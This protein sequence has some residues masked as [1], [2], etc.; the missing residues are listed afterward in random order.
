MVN[1]SRFYLSMTQTGV[2]QT[3]FLSDSVWSVA[4][5]HCSVCNW[6]SLSLPLKSPLNPHLT[7][8]PFRFGQFQ[9]DCT[10]TGTVSWKKL[11][12]DWSS[13]CTDQLQRIQCWGQ[14]GLLW[15][16]QGLTHKKAAKNEHFSQRGRVIYI[17]HAPSNP[18]ED[19][20]VSANKTVQVAT[21]FPTESTR[22][23]LK[24]RDDDQEESGW[25]RAAYCFSKQV[26]GWTGQS[27]G[28][29]CPLF[30]SVTVISKLY[31]WLNPRHTRPIVCTFQKCFLPVASIRDW[32]VWQTPF[33]SFLIF[34]LIH[35]NNAEPWRNLISHPPLNYIMTSKC[36]MQFWQAWCFS[37]R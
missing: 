15:E 22:K 12:P 34:F 3:V 21:F 1:W 25:T 14:G 30:S 29:F 20:C 16:A 2:L 31:S 33:I 13:M 9:L 32:K 37:G 6:I 11:W 27:A 7:P 8:P 35:Q 36:L 23:L 26:R 24:T 17:F 4:V 28:T 5:L 10:Q 18:P 19:L